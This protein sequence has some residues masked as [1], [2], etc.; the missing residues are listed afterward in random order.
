ML[1]DIDCKKYFYLLY[2]L[3]IQNKIIQSS[4]ANLY[5]KLVFPAPEININKIIFVVNLRFL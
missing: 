4:F 1:A 3:K 5:T 2:M